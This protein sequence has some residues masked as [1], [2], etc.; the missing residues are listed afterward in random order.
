M[1]GLESY[2]IVIYAEKPRKVVYS[3]IRGRTQRLSTAI[4]AEMD[5]KVVYCGL[6]RDEL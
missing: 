3:T 4:Y 1:D 6:C 5:G 2:A